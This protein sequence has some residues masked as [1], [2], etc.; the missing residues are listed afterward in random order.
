MGHFLS[1]ARHELL[2]AV[3]QEVPTRSER[4]SGDHALDWLLLL[5]LIEV[6]QRGKVVVELR[7]ANCKFVQAV[8]IELRVGIVEPFCDDHFSLIDGVLGDLAQVELNAILAGDVFIAEIKQSNAVLVK[9]GIFRAHVNDSTDQTNAVL[10]GL[11][12]LSELLAPQILLE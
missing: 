2:Q 11:A 3:I 4:P 6:L 10:N 1:D 9:R 12:E 8:H 7:W 5:K